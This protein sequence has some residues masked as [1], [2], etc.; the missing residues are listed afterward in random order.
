MIRDKTIFAIDVRITIQF[1][2]FNWLGSNSPPE[3]I[4][5]RRQ[6]NFRVAGVELSNLVTC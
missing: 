6:I 4:S 3:V 1:V 5:A 2:K